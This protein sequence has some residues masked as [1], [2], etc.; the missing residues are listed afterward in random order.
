MKKTPE[1]Y[2][3]ILD[4]Q[5]RR[6]RK[7]DRLLRR[8][9]D[10]NHGVAFSKQ[11]ITRHVHLADGYM[12]AADGLIELC[13]QPGYEHERHSVVYPILFNYRHGL[14]L[15]LKW[16]VVMYGGSGIEGIADTHNLWKLWKRCRAIVDEYRSGGK[17]ADDAIEQIVK[18]FH[19]LDKQGITFRYGWTNDGREIKLP[20]HMVDLNNLRDVMK[21][22][23]NYFTGLDGWLDDLQSAGP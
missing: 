1:R 22:V 23:E 13:T 10:W 18:D 16:F 12:S 19:D 6:P 7:G 11:P 15:K 5:H 8:S 4:M 14:E 20:D 17:E 21:G 3:D 9:D 2:T